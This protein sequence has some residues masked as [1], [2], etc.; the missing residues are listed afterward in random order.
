[1]NT[2]RYAPQPLDRSERRSLQ[3][4]RLVPSRRSIAVL[5]AALGLQAQPSP[6][7][8]A[9]SLSQPAAIGAS[10]ARAADAAAPVQLAQE[11]EQLQTDIR[12]HAR[13]ISLDDAI[14][15]G[16]TNNPQLL[17]AFNTI[18]QYEW[19]LISAQRQWYPSL[20][21]NNGSP[22]IGYN[23]Q[24]YAQNQYGIASTSLPVSSSNINY[25]QNQG[26][27]SAVATGGVVFQPGVN[28]SWNVIDPT[29]QPN[30]NAASQSLKQQKL[31]FDVSA[32]NLI[33]SIQQ[34]YY[35]VQSTQQLIDSFNEIY[36]I[37][38][39]QLSIIAAQRRIGMA[40][41]LDLEQQRSQLFIQLNLLV[42][43]TRDYISQTASLAQALGLSK[44]QLAIPSTAANMVGSWSLPLNATIDQA[45]SKREEILASLA[46][47]ESANWTG[48]AAIRSYLPVFQ[49]MGTA[50]LLG[51]NGYQSAPVG[52]DTTPHLTTST[53]LNAAA[54]LGFTWSLYDGG[55][56]A[57]NAQA[58]Y[59]QARQQR[60][61][62]A[63]TEL[64]V[65][66]QVRSSYG[67]YVTSRV[68][69]T[70]AQ[71]ALSSAKIA[72][73][74]SQARFNVGVGDITSV[75]QAIQQL[76]QSAELLASSLLS[77]NN[78]VAQLY[79]YSATWPLNTHQT[80]QVRLQQLR[81]APAR[82]P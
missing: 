43:Y 35:Q 4:A 44:R 16:L 55:V 57:S 28:L 26:I 50:S 40:T 63:T 34:S 32:R 56:Q 47:A 62:A 21:L 51:E 38:Q 76:S 48:I 27:S 17:Q 46:A 49:L 59:A 58:S 30:I 66:Q 42:Q 10:G 72:Q 20:Q 11:L 79:R 41:V 61:Q 78:A 19:Q 33:L 60:A 23:W 65:E 71:E 7:P 3:A 80:V 18:Q 12:Q 22:F 5:I 64:Q 37:N 1:M 82:K 69:V 31:L 54:G 67:Q 2:D 29:R 24:S 25:L 9:A 53:Y 39:R 81:Q 6:L 70:S 8:A 13:P 14:A 73:R 68:A 75:V 77:Y 15:I 45:L 74:A 36:A 52:G